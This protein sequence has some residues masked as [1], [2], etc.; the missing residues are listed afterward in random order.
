VRRTV[1]LVVL[2]MLVLG[3]V[4]L[5]Q[6]VVTPRAVGGGVFLFD[7]STG[8]TITKLGIIFD[9]TVTFTKSDVIALGGDAATLVSVSH[10]YAFIDVVVVPGGTLQVT[11]SG[12]GADAVVTSAFWFE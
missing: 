4:G 3:V 6:T 7:N 2:L 9:K 12:E 5:A 10:N 11:L 8:A 1:S